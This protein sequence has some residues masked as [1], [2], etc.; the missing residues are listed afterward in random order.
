MNE[1]YGVLWWAGVLWLAWCATVAAFWL[2]APFVMSPHAGPYTNGLRI[3][4]PPG[5]HRLLTVDEVAAVILHECGHIRHR[6]AARAALRCMVFYPFTEREKLVHELEADE[7]AIARGLAV[8][9][10]SALLKLCDPLARVNRRHK[11][12]TKQKRLRVREEEIQSS[13]SPT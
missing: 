11:T 4:L 2:A 12:E 7:H 3:V 5:L 1:A 6:H 13:S 8:P 10:H 9:L